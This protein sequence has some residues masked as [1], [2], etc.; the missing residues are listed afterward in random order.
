MSGFADTPALSPRARIGVLVAIVA[1]HILLGMAL[2][3]A[4]GGVRALT[5]QVGLGPV[6]VAMAPPAA[7]PPPSNSVAEHAHE[8]AGGAA[9]K[10]AS[11][12]QIVAPAPRLP[13]AAP[14]AAPVAGAGSETRSGAGASGEGTGGASTGAGPGSGGAGNGSG[15]R[16]ATTKPVKIAGDLVE[17]DYP[18][19]GRARRLGTAVIVILTVGADGQVSDCA[20]HQ[21]SGDPEAD[22]VTCKLARDRFRFTPAVDQNGDPIEAVYGWQQR[23]F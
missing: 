13:I 5:E 6:L 12:D 9:G 2:V 15:G 4:F 10:H 1:L 8:G 3:R 18:K 11:A 16:Y 17:S 21:P 20:V 19:A 14:P 23:F 22:A 7:P